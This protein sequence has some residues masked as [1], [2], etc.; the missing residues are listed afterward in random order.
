M[1]DNNFSPLRVY[2]STEFGGMSEENNFASALLAEPAKMGTVLSY[3]FGRKQNNVLAL[4]TG[5]IGNTK[6]IENREFDWDVHY[7]T[8]TVVDVIEN[9]PQAG[10]V[11]PG[12]GG[13][14]ID[15]ILAENFYGPGD[16]L[17][18]DR[19]EVTVR[20]LYDAAV[21]N[22]G[23]KYTVVN[24]SI[25]PFSFIDPSLISLGA[26]FSKDY[27]VQPEF[28]IKGTSATYQTPVKLRNQL[29]TMRKSFTV[30]R[31]AAKTIMVIEL[32]SAED[33]SKSTKM[34][35]KLVEWNELAAWYREVDAQM[36]YSTYN[37]T[38]D[39]IVEGQGNNKRP[40][41]TGAGLRE[42]ISPSNKKFYTT[43]TYNL[44]YQVLED[45]AKHQDLLM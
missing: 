2:A 38:P 20:V 37:K 3:A 5:G 17:V 8:G 43:L 44:L 32:T 45:Q 15:I 9:S 12:Y 40:I 1:L 34:W 39:F 26:R 27:N 19:S 18:T 14:P 31:S 35:T 28:S 13:L 25:D 10:Q 42:Q 33:P 16:I 29:T 7:Q 24:T 23:Y 21:W 36:L 4:L 22:G 41:Y 30:S 6:Y 11:T